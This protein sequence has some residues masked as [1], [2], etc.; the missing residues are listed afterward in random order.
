MLFHWNADPVIFSI[1]SISL[2]WYGV[3]FATGFLLGYCF[4]YINFKKRN[5]S[6]DKLDS[7]LFYML[8]GTVIGARLGHCIFYDPQYYLNNPIEIIKIWNGGL[9]S[10][11]GGIGL[12][13]STLIFCRINKFNFMNL[14]D[15]LCIPTAFVGG[16]IRL[17]N[18]FNS[19]I[20]GN[21]T[22]GDYGIIFDRID[23][24]A[25][26]PVQL[27]E[28]VS[29]FVISIFLYI[30][31]QKYTKRGSGFILGMF[32]ILVFIIRIFLEY[33]KPEQASYTTENSLTVGQYL[34]LPFIGAGILLCILSLTFNK[35]K[36]DSNTIIQNKQ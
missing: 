20:Y 30:L 10:H 18:F 1:S 6:T 11:G 22:N 33:F 15:L 21:K 36:Y 23:S 24:F 31:Y 34:S 2:R 29:Y 26:H 14:A 17:G 7:L 25:R 16:M 19:E 12:I 5:L 3:F 35:L 27:Y 28:S 13:I 4:T 32:L 9:A 8:A